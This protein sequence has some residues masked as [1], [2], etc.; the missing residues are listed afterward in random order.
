MHRV[1]DRFCHSRVGQVLDRGVHSRAQRRRDPEIEQ[2]RHHGRQSAQRRH[3][4]ESVP[5]V[6]P[7]VKVRRW[8][9]ERLTQLD[10]ADCTGG[11]WT[12]D[13]DHPDDAQRGRQ[14]PDEVG[15]DHRAEAVPDDHQLARRRQGVEHSSEDSRPGLLVTQVV[16]SLLEGVRLESDVH[17][18]AED[19]SSRRIFVPAEP[20]LHGARPSFERT[21]VDASVVLAQ[22]FHRHRR[23]PHLAIAVPER[24]CVL[25]SDPPILDE[26]WVPE[27]DQGP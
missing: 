1:A 22:V 10:R 7:P 14:P 4:V 24:P 12:P 20:V 9:L 23:E 18:A 13:G 11:D 19:R 8:F 16:P 21:T 17:G 6:D 2:P 5:E 25:R 27:P 26:L 15:R 3:G